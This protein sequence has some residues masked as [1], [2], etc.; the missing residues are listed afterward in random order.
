MKHE[1]HFQPS[2]DRWFDGESANEEAVKRHIETCAPC[3]AYADFLQRT[4]ARVQVLA[5]RPEIAPA[6]LSSFMAGIRREAEQPPRRRFAGF[7][8]V[9]SVACAAVI[10]SGSLFYLVTGG[11]SAV[12]ATEVESHGTEIVGAT[13]HLL[14][15]DDGTR[16][17]WVDIPEDAWEYQP[18]G[19][20]M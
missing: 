11:P 18:E 6:Q 1:C 15:S 9:A 2:I 10:A 20:M 17:V 4:R 5:G 12:V 16:T 3:A 7:W 14:V 13:T 8:A 19:D